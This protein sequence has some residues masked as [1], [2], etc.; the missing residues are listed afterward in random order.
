[1]IQQ[2]SVRIEQGGYVAEQ[3]TMLVE[4][5]RISASAHC[6]V[7]LRDQALEM[8]LKLGRRPD[9]ERPCRRGVREFLDQCLARGIVR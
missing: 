4:I 3:C 6:P 5:A 2:I 8:L 1:V 7:A 9:Q